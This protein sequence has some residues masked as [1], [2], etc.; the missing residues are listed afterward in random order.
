MRIFISLCLLFVL[1]CS[2]AGV[3]PFDSR[4]AFDLDRTDFHPGDPIEVKLLYLKEEPGREY[5][6]GVAAGIDEAPVDSQPIH[7]DTRS[8]MLT[9]PSPG[10]WTVVI[11][12]DGRMIAHR[13]IT[14]E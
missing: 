4:V 9:A 5:E 3:N 6:A 2:C 1:A 7:S 14:V 12:E 10:V 13:G 8:V 11:R